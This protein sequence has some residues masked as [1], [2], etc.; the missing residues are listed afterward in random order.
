MKQVFLTL[1][2]AALSA[3][4]ISNT[5]TTSSLTANPT[6]LADKSFCR[7]VQTD[8]SFGQPVGVRQHCL[9]FI[10]GVQVTDNANTFF[11]NPPQTGTYLL[12]GLTLVTEFVTR[13]G[14]EEK[15][16]YSLSS[17]GKKLTSVDGKRVL[18]LKTT[19]N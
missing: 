3:C 5:G 11:G 14:V 12:Q 7:S 9:T 10:N 15:N 6:N 4:G 1:T 18:T 17:D 19:K 16:I 13:S 2:L 8:G